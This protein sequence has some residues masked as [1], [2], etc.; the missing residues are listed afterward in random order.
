MEDARRADVLSMKP[1]EFRFSI[2]SNPGRTIQILTSTNLSK[3]SPWASVTNISGITVVTN[4]ISDIPARFFKL[5]IP[6]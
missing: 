4:R 3:W 5:E 6:N 1:G 2:Q